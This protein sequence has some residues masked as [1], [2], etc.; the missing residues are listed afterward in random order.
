MLTLKVVAKAP[1]T[2]CQTGM[3]CGDLERRMQ[4]YS[5]QV[6]LFIQK[7]QSALVSEVS[8]HPFLQVSQSSLFLGVLESRG[9]VRLVCDDRGRCCLPTIRY[10]RS[11]E[12]RSDYLTIEPGGIVLEFPFDPLAD[13]VVGNVK[14]K[15]WF[16]QYSGYVP[17]LYDDLL[18]ALG[19]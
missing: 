15:R 14:V 1:A 17:L 12:F 16:E 13:I 19:Y 9:N 7:Q 18:R 2:Q 11:R 6:I 10:V 8:W 4:Q 3:L 5:G